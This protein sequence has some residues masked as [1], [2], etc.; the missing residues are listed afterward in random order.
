[1]GVEE[2]MLGNIVGVKGCDMEHVVVSGLDIEDRTAEVV[3]PYGVRIN[4]IEEDIVGVEIAKENLL[5]FGFKE[6]EDWSWSMSRFFTKGNCRWFP[7]EGIL[8]V[9]QRDFACKYIHELQNI[10]KIA[11]YGRN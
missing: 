8:K 9:G 6:E 4:I 11:N 1:M 5:N 10:I 2:L 3:F 7:N